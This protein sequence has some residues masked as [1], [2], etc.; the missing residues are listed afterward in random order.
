MFCF[1]K[2][3]KIDFAFSQEVSGP[4]SDDL[5]KSEVKTII[6]LELLL[7]SKSENYLSG[8]QN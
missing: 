1:V 3:G 5:L 4:T 2:I 6:E 8:G 7:S